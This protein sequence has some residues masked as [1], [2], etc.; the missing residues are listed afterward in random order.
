MNSIKKLCT[1]ALALTLAVLMTVS[2][3]PAITIES[4]AITYSG[5]SSSFKNGKYGQALAALSKTGNQRVDIVNV[6]KTQV[7]Y[8]EGGY[9]G[10]TRGSNNVT[11]YGR[12]YGMQDMWCAMFVSW[13]AMAA[14]IST[15][16]VPSHS[17]TPTGLNW[18]R[19][20]GQAYKRSTVASGGYTPIAGDI[21]YFKS[22]RNTNIT[23]HIGIVTSY[24]NG[25]VYTIEGNTSSAT[26][27]TNGGAVAAKSY[28]ITDTYI[29]YICKPAYTTGD[30][31]ATTSFAGCIDTGD[32]GS[33]GGAINESITNY[34]TVK[35][36]DGKFV[37]SGWGV[38][39]N[40]VDH[41]EYRVNGGSWVGI[42][43]DYRADVAN[44][45]PDFKNCTKNAYSAE[46]SLSNFTAGSNAVEIRG[47]SPKG[48]TFT[49]GTLTV[50]VKPNADETSMSVPLADVGCA[51]NGQLM[52]TAKGAHPKAWV[53]IFAAND[54]PGNVA[55]YRWYEMGTTETTFDLFGSSAKVNSRGDIAPGDYKIILFVDSGYVIDKTINIKITSATL[56]SLDTPTAEENRTWYGNEG[57]KVTTTGW[58]LHES[59]INKFTAVID[60]SIE[61]ELPKSERP[62]VLAAYPSYTD[63]CGTNTGFAGTVDTTGLSVGTHTVTIFA[64][65]NTGSKFAVGSFTVVTR[66]KDAK[67]TVENTS[68]EIGDEIYVT[69]ASKNPNAW[70]GLYLA[71]D[72][73]YETTPFYSYKISEVGNGD[74][75]GVAVNLLSKT[76]STTRKLEAGKYKVVLF[77]DSDAWSA[78]ANNIVEIELTTATVFNSCLD[79][80]TNA[81]TVYRGTSVVVRGWGISTIG[82][83]RYELVIDDGAPIILDAA[84]R[85]DVLKA[86]PDFATVCK[87]LHAFE[88]SVSTANLTANTSHTF[89][90]RALLPN[91]KYKVVGTADVFVQPTAEDT[92]LTTKA[93]SGAVIKREENKAPV[94]TGITEN[95]TTESV[96]ELFNETDCIIVDKNGKENPAIVGTGATVVRKDSE[97]KV[98]DEVTV[99]VSGDLD[100]DGK[101]TSKD[102]ILS[103]LHI[104]NTVK[105]EYTDAI[106]MSGDGSCTANDIDNMADAMLSK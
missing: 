61:T 54:V 50:F 81:Q 72:V 17:Y 67:L 37:L 32:T 51:V 31:V 47:V 16:I 66:D 13:C 55:S 96:K 94:I 45:L 8:Q 41:F 95:S 101:I 70:V 19:N 42:G 56:G 87:D 3:L 52:V 40:G 82:I 68:F 62:D 106:D 24:S 84:Q 78:D 74:G 11:E 18:F 100:G 26:V 5:I 65:P 103:K 75:N 59:G 23:N 10:T 2:L 83:T 64:H 58:A 15:S 73:T 89:T 9:A 28:N 6:A 104:N 7:G 57:E 77:K 38:H 33:K 48:D 12:W 21:I 60:N 20:K 27:S 97:G 91:G 85:D 46:V 76:A 29:V 34:K 39:S 71:T 14:G 90:V 102:I 36:S 79:G 92:Q 4:N 44:A 53:G 105:T 43:A 69:A 25:K 80:P 49:I 63:A 22:P 1:S 99:I 35:R 88:S 30:S 93:D 86:F 98:L